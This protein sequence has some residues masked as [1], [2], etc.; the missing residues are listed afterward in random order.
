VRRTL[1]KKRTFDARLEKFS[2]EYW[3]RTKALSWGFVKVCMG[4]W[5]WV[6]RTF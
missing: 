5:V 1:G 6:L 2:C 3:L 4:F